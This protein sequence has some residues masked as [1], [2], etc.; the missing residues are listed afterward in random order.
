MATRYIH[1]G[2]PLGRIFPRTFTG[3]A[4]LQPFRQNKGSLQAH[5][6]GDGGVYVGSGEAEWYAEVLVEPEGGVEVGG[7]G[8]ELYLFTFGTSGGVEVGGDATPIGV[9]NPSGEGGVEVG[10]D[11]V[12]LQI[13]VPLV[14]ISGGSATGGDAAAIGQECCVSGE[15]GVYVGSG[16]VTWT[17]LVLV[18]PDGGV[19]VGGDAT[20]IGVINPSGE[21]GVQTGGDGVSLQVLVPLVAISG[22][23]ATGG[24][25]NTLYLSVVIPSGLGGALT[26]GD[27]VEYFQSGEITP[28]GGISVGGDA[29]AVGVINP[30]GEGGVRTGGDGVAISVLIPLVGFSG[31]VSVGGDAN[32]LYVGVVFPS[33]LGGLEVG[34]DEAYS[35]GVAPPNSYEEAATSGGVWVGGY[36]GAIVGS[37]SGTDFVIGSTSFRGPT[38]QIEIMHALRN[39]L[40]NAGVFADNQAYVAIEGQFNE[41]P[42]HDQYAV[43]MPGRKTVQQPAF[44]GAGLYGDLQ[45]E[46][47]EVRI[48]HRHF[49]DQRNK[50]TL[51]TVDRGHGA[52]KYAR[53]AAAKMH[54]HDLADNSGTVLVAEPIRI[55]T[56]GEPRAER[57][58][59]GYGY[60]PIF[61]E[62]TYTS[63]LLDDAE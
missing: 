36:S 4:W 38:N 24:D 51:W 50:A 37:L 52:Y 59:A 25:A 18:E 9:I 6:T 17:A 45:T 63:D 55:Q 34:G 54:G 7:S 21:G 13:L 43:I 44:T 61:V 2:Q 29:T 23:S 15:G 49:L 27:A 40:V 53:L 3:Q 32:A 60:I 56:I 19:S 22:G 14:A 48:Y 5:L 58:G 46:V 30:S 41:T 35:S 62:V 12:A 47:F 20:P 16:E 31:G 42:P 39:R 57:Q 33:G 10:G 1:F 8:Q 28:E 11:G 26:G